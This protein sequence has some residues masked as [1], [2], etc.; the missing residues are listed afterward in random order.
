MEAAFPSGTR[1]TVKGN[2]ALE[3]HRWPNPYSDLK[4]GKQVSEV[5][6]TMGEGLPWEVAKCQALQESN[7]VLNN[8]KFAS[9]KPEP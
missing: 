7:S 9:S 5:L 3:A 4:E 2:G 8:Q 1:L 6:V